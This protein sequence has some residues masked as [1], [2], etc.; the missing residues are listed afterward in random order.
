M[1]TCTMGSSRCHSPVQPMASFETQSPSAGCQGPAHRRSLSNLPHP[2]SL[3]HFHIPTSPKYFLQRPCLISYLRKRFAFHLHLG[4]L[5]S[6][7]ADG[8]RPSS[9]QSVS[10]NPQPRPKKLTHH[11]LSI[12]GVFFTLCLC[13]STR[14]HRETT[15]V[16]WEGPVTAVGN[17]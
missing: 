7:S 5:C 13:A 9:Y 12:S 16:V 8:K 1:E 14:S 11:A 17:M 15:H 10:K 4:C 6:A 2:F 3:Q